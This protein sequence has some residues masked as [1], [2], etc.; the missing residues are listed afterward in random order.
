[1][2]EQAVGQFD[3]G[4]PV[5]L[6][7]AARE[8]FRRKLGEEHAAGIRLGVK[9]SGCT[10]Y[11]Y[12]LDTADGPRG[13]DLVLD[14]GE[15]VRLFVE[16]AALPILRGTRIEYVREGINRVLKFANPNARDYCGCGESF[17]VQEESA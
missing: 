11:A 4:Q 9:E 12:V 13:D 3:P 5:T 6:D 15:G 16:R 17:S 8:H 14:F 1:M 10:G 7:E 2:N